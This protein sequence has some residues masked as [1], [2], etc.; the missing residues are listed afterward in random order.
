[1]YPSIL[2]WTF[3]VLYVELVFYFSSVSLLRFLVLFLNAWE[4]AVVVDEDDI[5]MGE[6]QNEFIVG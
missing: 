2:S 4:F 5:D 1:M 3:G 6:C